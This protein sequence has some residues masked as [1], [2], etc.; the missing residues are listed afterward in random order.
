MLNTFRHLN[1][2]SITLSAFDIIYSIT[3][4]HLL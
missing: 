3:M 2:H 4:H 1:E